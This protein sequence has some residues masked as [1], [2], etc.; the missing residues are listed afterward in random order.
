MSKTSRYILFGLPLLVFLGLAVL[1]WTQLGHDPTALPS[2]RLGKP[3]PAFQLSTLDDPMHV[4]TQND[5][6]GK[7]QLLNVWA[8]WCMT[9]QAEHPILKQLAD[10][11]VPIVGVNYK[12]YRSA[13]LQFLSNNGN[14]Y[15]LTIFDDAGSF[16]LDLGVYGAP[17]TYLIDQQ[18]RVRYRYV[19]ALDPQVWDSEF[20]PLYNALL[21]GQPLPD[22]TPAD[23]GA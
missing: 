23:K 1:F 16:G 5:L 11:G 10:A 22:V 4:V 15:R 20:K 18:G 13:A 19:G 3:L 2:A 14:P 21:Q 7:V 9:C 6:K 12:D 8:T 17:E